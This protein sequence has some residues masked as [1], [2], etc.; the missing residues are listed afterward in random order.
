MLWLSIADEEDDFG[1]IVDDEDQP[2][3]SRPTK[4]KK[5]RNEYVSRYASIPFMMY[6]YRLLICIY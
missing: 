2:I 5:N 3:Q 4:K 1:F 6:H